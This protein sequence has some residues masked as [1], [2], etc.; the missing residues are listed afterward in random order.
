MARSKYQANKRQKE[1]AR[2]RKQELK[3]QQK[4]EKKLGGVEGA[5]DW[6]A[7]PA[8]PSPDAEASDAPP[9]PSPSAEATSEA[10]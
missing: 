8:E 7:I 9:A 10:D 3:R 2:E 4:L 1:I 6:D 5:E